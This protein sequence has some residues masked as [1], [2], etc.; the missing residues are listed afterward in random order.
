MAF[1]S[2]VPGSPWFW[3]LPKSL[4]EAVGIASVR[5][6]SLDGTAHE[7]CL[8]LGVPGAFGTLQGCDLTNLAA[9]A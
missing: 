5:F 4:R 7:D 1:A 3:L 2:W 6:R 8:D 9:L